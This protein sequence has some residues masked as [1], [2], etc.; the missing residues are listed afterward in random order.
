[1]IQSFH[2]IE[3]LQEGMSIRSST[4]ARIF[5]LVIGIL[6]FYVAMVFYS[7]V[8]KFSHSFFN[9]NAYL[10]PLV[11][12]SSTVAFLIRSKRQQVLLD[13]VGVNMSFKDNILLYFSGQSMIATPGGAGEVIK[14]HYIKNKTGTPRSQTIPV[15]LIER[16]FDFLG[17]IS[18]LIISLFF[19]DLLST[20]ILII[21]ALGLLVA[22]FGIVRNTNI[23]TK[24]LDKISKIRFF[25]NMTQNS[26]DFVNSLLLLSNK[27]IMFKN[28]LITIPSI[29]FDGLSIYFAFMVFGIKFDYILT[30]Q[31]SFTSILFGAI[32][33]IPGGI[34]I[35]EGSLV[36]FLVSKKVELSIASALVLFTRLSTLWYATIL[37]FITTKFIIHNKNNLKT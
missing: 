35:T 10:I 25:N 24:F 8:M 6:V 28:F 7:D 18:F 19:Y 33:F 3:N 13:K 11:L 32:S 16:I 20:K 21:F 31:L 23:L 29:F 30:T 9:I 22:G 1:M 26:Q 34:G 36:G 2:I 5:V 17:I 12:L 27:K 37:G 15:F 4:K 14:S